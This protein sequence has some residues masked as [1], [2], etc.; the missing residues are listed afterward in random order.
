MMSGSFVKVQLSKCGIYSSHTVK[1]QSLELKGKLT[2]ASHRDL[3]VKG[4][5]S[6]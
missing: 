3:V 6:H 4:L 5:G 2:N 1:E